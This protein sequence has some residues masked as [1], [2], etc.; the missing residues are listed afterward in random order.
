MHSPLN[1][2]GG[3]SKLSRVIVPMIPKNHTCYCEPF[4]GAAWVFFGKPESK[5]EV[6]ND[7]DNELVTFWRVIQNHLQPFLDYFKYAIVS[8]QIFEWERTKSP[9]TLT[10]IQRAVRY[11]YLQRLGFGGKTKG[12]TFG[13]T[14]TRP[15]NLNLTTIEETLLEVHWRLERVTIERLDALECIRRYDRPSTFFFID[16][17]YFHNTN[18]YAVSFDRFQELAKLLSDLDGR[19]ILSLGDCPEVRLI[20]DAFTQKKVT[21]TYSAANSRSAPGSRGKVRSE[22][23]IHNLK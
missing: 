16:P 19:F 8:R 15:S 12:R 13:A 14:V 5:Q 11:Y 23:L 18:D 7:M 21:L 9:E 20:F 10:D 17:P 2:L 6:I 22:L 1:Y 4:C 3:K